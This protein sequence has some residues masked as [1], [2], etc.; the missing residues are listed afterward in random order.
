MTHFEYIQQQIAECATSKVPLCQLSFVRGL[1]DMAE[2]TQA[3]TTGESVRLGAELLDQGH[4]H[5]DRLL[6][7]T[8]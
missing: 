3:I 8:R 2:R 6:G 1:I 4:A 5:T 7:R